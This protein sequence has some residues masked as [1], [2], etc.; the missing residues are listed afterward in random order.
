MAKIDIVEEPAPGNPA[1][2]AVT[3]ERTAAGVAHAETAGPAAAI[4]GEPAALHAPPVAGQAA[5]LAAADIADIARAA[6]QTRVGHA[7]AVAGHPVQGLAA[8]HFGGPHAEAVVVPAAAH[9]HPLQ[10]ATMHQ[11]E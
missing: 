5:A 9:T 6:A 11:Q 10:T 3:G 2:T 1:G 4:A 7:A 8:D